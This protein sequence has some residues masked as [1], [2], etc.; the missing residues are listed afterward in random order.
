MEKEDVVSDITSDW[1]KNV[2]IDIPAAVGIDSPQKEGGKKF[3]SSGRWKPF[4]CELFIVNQIIL[5]IPKFKV[6]LS[7][8]FFL[9]TD[10]GS[11]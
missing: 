3:H 8:F 7:S 9:K 6:K 5:L 11:Y 10:V 4:F 2:R 1:I